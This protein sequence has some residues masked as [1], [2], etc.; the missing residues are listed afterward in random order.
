V[1]ATLIC[2]DGQIDRWVEANM[3]FSQY[4][5]EDASLFVIFGYFVQYN[6]LIYLKVITD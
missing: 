3:H 4:L 5:H 6:F 2:A 1:E